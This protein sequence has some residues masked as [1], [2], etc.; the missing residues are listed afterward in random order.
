MVQ[1]VQRWEKGGGRRRGWWQGDWLIALYC[2]RRLSTTTGTGGCCLSAF[3]HLHLLVNP[4][5][6]SHQLIASQ[7]PWCRRLTL[8]CRSRSLPSYRARPN[9]S[10]PLRSGHWD[11]T[12]SYIWWIHLFG[13]CLHCLWPFVLPQLQWEP[14]P[15]VA[16]LQTQF[17]V[18]LYLWLWISSYPRTGYTSV[19]LGSSVAWVS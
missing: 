16:A 19:G 9:S 1:G 4:I 10:K 3:R 17:G 11:P 15:A 2:G 12:C 5:S 7:G 6:C 14:D 13:A 18:C 8:V